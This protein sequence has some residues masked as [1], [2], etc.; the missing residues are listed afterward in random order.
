LQA[1]DEKRRY[2]KENMRNSKLKSQHAAV[3]LSRTFVQEIELKKVVC[4]YL[5]IEYAEGE[6][7]GGK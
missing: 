1:L 3:K 2:I 7:E 6:G 5:H 4:R